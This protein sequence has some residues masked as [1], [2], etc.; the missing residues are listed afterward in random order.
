MAH[1]TGDLGEI[2]GRNANENDTGE[3]V[4]LTDE[5]M[6]CEDLP[7]NDDVEGT[8]AQVPVPKVHDC[9]SSR[10]RSTAKHK[11]TWKSGRV[12]EDGGVRNSC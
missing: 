7:V 2:G 3:W 5:W 12:D 1:D 6:A 8:V 11:N 10:S 4:S 9:C